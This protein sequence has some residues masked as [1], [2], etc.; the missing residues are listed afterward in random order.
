MDPST[1]E[2]SYMLHAAATDTQKACFRVRITLTGYG[3]ELSDLCAM[4]VEL[5]SKV[6][7]KHEVGFGPSVELLAGPHMRGH[8]CLQMII[9][10]EIDKEEA[11]LSAMLKKSGFHNYEQAVFERSAY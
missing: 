6:P 11:G 1:Y 4:D 8:M 5:R 2:L 3:H 10:P 9:V 7:F